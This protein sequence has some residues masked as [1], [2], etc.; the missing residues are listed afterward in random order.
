MNE[1][2]SRNSE[3]AEQQ[4]EHLIGVLLGKLRNLLG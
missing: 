1:L 4:F 2:S 3:S